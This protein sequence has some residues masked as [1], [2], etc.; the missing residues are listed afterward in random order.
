MAQ[1]FLDM[2]QKIQL[3]EFSN[4][5][6][7]FLI[8][9]IIIDG[10][11]WFVAA[12][13][14]KS[15]DYKN[16]NDAIK[17]H[18]KLKAIE[19]HDSLKSSTG[20]KLNLINEPNVYRL[21]INSK[22]KK[23]EKFEEWV[24]EEILP[25]IRRT[26]GYNLARKSLPIYFQRMLLNVNKTKSGYF[27]VIQEMTNSVHLRF[28]SI[29]YTI[30]DHSFDGTELRPDTSVGICFANYLKD[31]YPHLDAKHKRY[32]HWFLTG[33]KVMARQYPDELLAMFREFIINV[34]IPEK[35]E[36]YFKARDPKALDY[37]PKL[38]NKKAS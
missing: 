6:E 4:E 22:L 16:Y 31:Y 1:S 38:L 36:K 20:T 24:F 19:K 30:P 21:I 25:E 18:C 27:S 5:K 32:E 35:A 2:D 15:L 10:K 11:T 3:L 14:A 26:G 33:I 23:S 7:N 28:E 17:R 8:R 34:W 29:G 9:S 37:L 13:I 12:D